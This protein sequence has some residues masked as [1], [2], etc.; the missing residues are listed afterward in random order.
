MLLSPKYKAFLRHM[1]ARVEVLEGT[2]FA[3]KTTVGVFK[4]MLMV[5][6][7]PQRYHIIAGLDLGTLEKNIINADLGI[8]DLF[9][10]RAE[11]KANGGNNITL[12]HIVYHT[13]A[14][15][16]IIYTLGYDNKTRWK[17]ALGGQYGCVYVDEANIADMEFIRE[18][19]IRYD[20]WMMTLN[21]DDPDLPVY[22]E[23][24]NKSRSLPE[25]AHET[26]PELL[27]QLNQPENPDWIHWYFSFAHNPSITEEKKQ[28][29]LTGVP[30]DS[31][32]YKNK[33]LGLRGR[34]TGLIF[35]LEPKHIITAEQ[36]KKYQ[37][38]MFSCGVDTSYSKN[39][40]DTLAFVYMGITNCGRLIILAEE[41]RNNR[42]RKQPFSPSD[43][44]PLLYDF[45]EKQRNRWGFARDI[46][47]D[48]ADQATL[49]ECQKYKRQR[50]M[51]Y[52][53]AGAWKQTKIIDRIN[54]QGGWMQD[55]YWYVLED[56]KET[57]REHNLYCWKEDK[58]EPVDSNDHTINAGQY[59]WLPYKSK[60]GVYNNESDE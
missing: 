52:Q 34:A 13:G 23:Y 30:L 1:S 11:Y 55:G 41:V 44:A 42:D 22:K 56:C 7:N 6:L 36:A 48:S 16:K 3:G 21:P 19:S 10:H 53:F 46:F 31:K 38:A 2:T 14:G 49:F 5:A 57:I 26:P 18:V 39:S 43:V 15:D 32:L 37:F 17:K 9:G 58:H 24:I 8:L 27:E 51:L 59:G 40:P 35:N 12:P 29:L 54:L 47:I 4:Y 60:I 25:W 45:M 28:Q 20:Y 50:H 33:I